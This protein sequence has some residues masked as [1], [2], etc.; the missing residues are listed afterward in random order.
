MEAPQ[1][2]FIKLIQ[3]RELFLWLINYL[4]RFLKEI[5]DVL[6]RLCGRALGQDVSDL[7]DFLL[8]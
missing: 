2:G 7:V 5:P 4:L 1:F 6:Q 8:H 3:Y